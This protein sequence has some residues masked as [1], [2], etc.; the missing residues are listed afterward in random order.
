MNYFA[1]NYVVRSS[2]MKEYPYF[3][4]LSREKY[5]LPLRS[6]RQEHVPPPSRRPQWGGG[7]EHYFRRKDLQS[8]QA[9]TVGFS[10]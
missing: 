10:S 6:E 7:R 5:I 9:S 8:V 4:R 1:I 3:S 2:I